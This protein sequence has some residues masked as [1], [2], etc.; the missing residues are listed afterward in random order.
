M[1]ISDCV[2]LALTKAKR[3]NTDLCQYLGLTKLQTLNNKFIRD[4]WSGKDLVKVAE[5]TGAKL[6]LVYPDELNIQIRSDEEKKAEE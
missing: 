5:L 2:R 6:M 3:K 1:T 4:S